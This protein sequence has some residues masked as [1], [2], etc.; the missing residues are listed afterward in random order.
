MNVYWLTTNIISM[1]QSQFLKI[2]PVREKFGI[3]ELKK[4]KDTDLPMNQ[5]S[6]FRY[7]DIF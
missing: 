3:G 5:M 1:T 7:V 2:K 4:W 6:L